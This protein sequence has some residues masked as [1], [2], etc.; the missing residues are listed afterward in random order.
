MK[1]QTRVSVLVLVGAGVLSLLATPRAWARIKLTT[2]PVRERVEVQLDNPQATLVEEERIV[3]LLQGTNHIDFSWSNTAIDKGTIQFR[4]VDIP[5]RGRRQGDPQSVVRP[6]GKVEMI[7]VINVAY[8]PGENA[9]VWEVFAEKPFAAR[10]R[11]SYLIARLRR[12]FNYRAVA[13]NDE[14]TLVLRNYIRLDNFSGEEFGTSGIWA[15]F[16]K[17][18]HREVGLNEAKQMLS[19]KFTEVPVKKTFTFNWWTGQPVP[20]EPEQRYV[21]MRYVLTN[22][23]KHS[24]GLFPLQPGKVRIFQ[25]DGHGGEAFIGEDWGKFTPIDDEMKLYL[26]LARDIVVKRKVLSNRRVPEQHNLYHQEIV[27]QYTIENFKTEPAVLDIIEDMNRLRDTFS[28]RKDHDAQWEIVRRGTSIGQSQIERKDSRT[29]EFHI[30]LAK[31]PGGDD[32]VKPV[33]ATVH[34]FL[35]NEW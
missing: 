13:E 2:L 11:I 16:G 3:T 35:R 9:L 12:S 25:K 26:G 32:L 14:S 7:Q 23:K 28:G 5:L 15:G 34:L 4:V 27:L 31:A 10:V 21:E 19:W 30:P 33:V 18:F 22:D 1:G 17:Y 20:E 8:P 6:D 24:L 29:A